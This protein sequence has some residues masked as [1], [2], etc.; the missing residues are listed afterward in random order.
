MRYELR[1]VK[2]DGDAAQAGDAGLLDLV[3]RRQRAR[4]ESVGIVSDTALPLAA[5]AALFVG[6]PSLAPV[7]F[8]DDN[9]ARVRSEM[10]LRSL[11]ASAA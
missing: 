7:A 2:C 6:L 3:D 1:V 10:S 4:G 11:S 5:A 9:A 8:R